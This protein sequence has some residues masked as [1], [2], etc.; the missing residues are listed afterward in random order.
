MDI[1]MD[2]PSCPGRLSFTAKRRRG[3]GRLVGSCDA[4]GSVFSLFGG[5][6]TPIDTTVDGRAAAPA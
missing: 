6:I 1:E 2:C 3:S 5:R 4:C